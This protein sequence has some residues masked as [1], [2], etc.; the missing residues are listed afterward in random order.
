MEIHSAT[1]RFALACNTSSKIIEPIQS[2]C[3]IL[4]Y[5]RLTSPEIL[6]RLLDIAKAEGVQYTAE[7]MEALIFTAEGDLRQAIN[8]MQATVSGFGFVSP[9][10]VFKVCDQP[11]PGIIEGILEACIKG[12]IELAQ[13][14]MDKLCDLGYA[15]VDMVGTF[16]RVIKNMPLAKISEALQL[17]FIKVFPSDVV[18]CLCLFRK[19]E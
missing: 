4:R 5:G 17:E 14:G 13:E 3:A 2:R 11:H 16:F 18:P 7:G 8:N 9:E 1:T 6:K 10:N 15:P 12:D 19:S